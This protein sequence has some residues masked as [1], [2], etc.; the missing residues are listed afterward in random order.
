MGI[1]I[2]N[3][4]WPW[5]VQAALDIDRLGPVLINPVVSGS[6][7][8]SNNRGTDCKLVARNMAIGI[9]VWHPIYN[10]SKKRHQ[11]W[12][13]EMALLTG[14]GRSKT[15]TTDEWRWKQRHDNRYLNKK[16]DFH[17]KPRIVAYL[18]EAFSEWFSYKRGRSR[19]R[20][21]TRVCVSLQLPTTRPGRMCAT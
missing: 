11:V 19:H 10:N 14:N 3:V 18:Y 8:L 17:N 1:K 16:L 2:A 7:L 20:G 5:R 12:A 6:R 9:P 4:I 15:T 13:W 21:C